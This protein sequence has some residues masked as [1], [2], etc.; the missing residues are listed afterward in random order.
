V[1]REG[2]EEEEEEAPKPLGSAE[3]AATAEGAESSA[4]E[5]REERGESADAEW[6]SRA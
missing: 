5:L 3:A 1:L 4:V 2:A 6:M